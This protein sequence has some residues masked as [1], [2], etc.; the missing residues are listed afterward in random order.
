MIAHTAFTLLTRRLREVSSALAAARPALVGLA[1]LAIV[2]AAASAQARSAGPG[3]GRGVAGSSSAA[4]SAADS[5]SRP[6]PI[7]GVEQQD[8]LTLRRELFTYTTSGRRDPF[9]S[10]M[11]TE[12][13]RPLVSDLRLVAVAWDSDGSSTVAIL[14][15]LQTNEQYRAKVGQLLGRLRVTSIA[16][17]SITFTIEEFGFSRQETL[18]LGDSPTQRTQQ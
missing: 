8:R 16:R 2:P 9:V 11:A 1:L 5:N 18:S 12:E 3:P 10:L 15:D 4:Y 13:L 17:K 7:V 6:V 14:R